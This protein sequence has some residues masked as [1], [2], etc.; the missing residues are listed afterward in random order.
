LLRDAPGIVHSSKFKD[1]VPAT[2]RENL[3]RIIKQQQK[4]IAYARQAAYD[5]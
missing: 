1:A 3:M 2:K 5:S 4:E